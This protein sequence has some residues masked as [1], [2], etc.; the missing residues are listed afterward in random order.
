M[1]KIT[2]ITSNYDN[3]YTFNKICKNLIEEYCDDFEFSFF[4]SNIIDKS[5]EEY[6]KLE[7]EIKTSNI[8]Y[9]LLHGGVSSF[10]KFMNLKNIFWGKIPFFINTTISDENREFVEHGGVPVTT[11]YN[12]AKYYTLGGEENCK[13]MILYTASELGD[14][15]YPYEKYTYMRWEGI[16]NDGNAVEDEEN[17]IKKI[18]K[19]PMVIAVLFHGKEWNSKRIKVVDK[20]IEELKKLGV[21]P[22]PIFTN[23]ILKPEIKSK[24]IK[25]VIENYLKY[26][27]KVIPKVIINLMAY[28]Q[29]IFSDPGD[30]TSI[31]EKSI[32]E[33]LEIPVIQAM[34]TYQN[35]ETWEKDIRG[36]DSE[37]LTTGVYYPEFD[38]QIISVTCCTYESIRDEYG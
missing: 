26:K 24:G 20:F 13:N 4:K 2:F 33:E 32:F 12:M 38:G 7:E 29:T 31:V 21:V 14:K 23:S 16:Y 9:I 19:E 35:R 6:G 28:S 22:Y 18:A 17:F 34:S 5:D 15:K 8:V 10:K 1:F 30:G 11:A 3:S 37:A 27:G 36:L 25:W